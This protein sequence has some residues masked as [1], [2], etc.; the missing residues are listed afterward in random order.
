MATAA[1]HTCHGTDHFDDVFDVLAAHERELE[2]ELCQVSTGMATT[3]VETGP[4][5]PPLKRR[6]SLFSPVPTKRLAYS[7][8]EWRER[9]FPGLAERRWLQLLVDEEVYVWADPVTT[10]QFM[11]ELDA[12]GC[13]AGGRPLSFLAHLYAYHSRTPRGI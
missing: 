7:A 9:A 4:S 8:S 1:A 2:L 11:P 3:S 5:K 12:S 6:T 13:F 10:R